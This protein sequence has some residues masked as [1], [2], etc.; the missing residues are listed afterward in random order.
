MDELTEDYHQERLDHERELHYN[1]DTQQ[2]E[3]ILQDELR[4]YKNLVVRSHPNSTRHKGR[5][6]KVAN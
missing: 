3:R 4:K 6:P 5:S 1:R 2:R